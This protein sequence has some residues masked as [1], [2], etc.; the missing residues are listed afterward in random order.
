M[1]VF[2]SVIFLTLAKENKNLL[3]CVCSSPSEFFVCF[4]LCTPHLAVGKDINTQ[5]RSHFPY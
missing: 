1:A 5:Q 4:M 3:P 2:T